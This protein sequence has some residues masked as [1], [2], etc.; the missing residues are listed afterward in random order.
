MGASY[1]SVS[2]FIRHFRHESTSTAKLL[3][4]ISE[5]HADS[6]PTPGVRSLRR[7]SWHLAKSP[8][9]FGEQ[10]GLPTT[11]TSEE[12]KPSS[13]AGLA[14]VYKSSSQEL[15][16]L[17][18]SSVNDE[19]LADEILAFGSWKMTKGEMLY[20]VLSHD[21][22]HRGQMQIIMRTV[23]EIPVGVVGPT[24]E[25]EAAMKAA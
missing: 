9:G 4:S 13:I 20:L 18:E 19:N 23:G 22:H 1:S 3:S 15:L 12:S 8:A 2:E 17:V 14:E 11:V 16:S 21:I 10:M 6:E 7:L 24:G 25:E 5:D